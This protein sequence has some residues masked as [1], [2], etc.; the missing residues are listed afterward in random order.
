MIDDK[1]IAEISQKAK[2][3]RCSIICMLA[4]AGS[5][6]TAGAL[7]MADI[8]ATLYFEVL[9]HEPK[10]PSYE[11]RDLLVLSNGHICPV[12]YASMAHSGYFPVENLIELRKFGSVFQGHPHR[13][14][15]PALETSSG[16]LGS[17]LSQASGMALSLKMNGGHS[18]GRFVYCLTGDGE[19]DEGQ[20][21]EAFMFI[22]KNNLNNLITIIDRNKIQIDGPTESV[23][24]LEPLAHKIESFGLNAI[25]I[26]GNNIKEIFKAIEGAKMDKTRPT[27]IIANT[28]PSKGVPEWEGKYEW[29]GKAPSKDEA[30]MALQALEK[31]N[32][33]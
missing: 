22:A 19:L 8:F 30:R 31:E 7:G 15:L 12:L 14:F 1:E 2:E 9:R 26:D 23:M 5:G 25:E 27:V 33:K 10:N 18:S 4:A 17:G 3:I 11:Y 21:W 6:H 20:N 13:E 28:I 32:L 16:P 29:H 24:P